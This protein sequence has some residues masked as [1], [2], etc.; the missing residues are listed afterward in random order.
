MAKLFFTNSPTNFLFFKHSKSLTILMKRT[1]LLT[2]LCVFG[3]MC[4]YAQEMTVAGRVTESENGEP[5]PG[6]SVR[7]ASKSNRGTLTDLEGNYTLKMP[8]DETL[9]FSAV[10]FSCQQTIED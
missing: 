2:L 9:I 8:G 6:V 5:I 10:G 7:V 1:L 3:A 4:T